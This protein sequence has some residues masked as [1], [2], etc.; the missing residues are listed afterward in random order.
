MKRLTIG[1]LTWAII[2]AAC[3]YFFLQRK[4]DAKT[5]T[6]QVGQYL[7]GSRQFVELKF[8]PDQVFKVGDIL[9]HHDS[10]ISKPIGIITRVDTP[11]S[12]EMGL[13]YSSTAYA[14]L[15]PS[16]PA[17]S[18]NDYV[19][20]HS[21]PDS[22]AWVM[23][24]M[25]P[26]EKRKEISE[27]ILDTY[28]EN[29]VELAGALR[30]I[31]QQTI[32]ESARIIQRDLRVA[33]DSRSEKIQQVSRRLQ[34]DLVK[35]DLIP[36]L[37]EEI[38]PVIKREAEPVVDQVGQEIWKEAS[39]W[40]F[41]WRYLYDST[42]LPKRDLTR[43]EFDR[44]VEETAVPILEGHVEDFLEVQRTI[45]REVSEN[46]RVQ[47]VVS[48]SVREFV[49]DS[50]VQALFAEIVQE[51]LVANP[52]LQSV[53]QEI[54]SS[55]EARTA[56]ALTNQ[57]LEPTITKIGESL[58]GNPTKHITPEFSWALRSRI[59]QKD[60]RWLSLVHDVDAPL[61]ESNP[62]LKVIRGKDDTSNPFHIPARPRNGR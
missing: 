14:K 53:W 39:V 35:E 32:Q 28:K 40:R 20:Y 56:L 60:A 50:E 12:N 8:N 55:D 33:L 9:F 24:V 43:K 61:Q 51:V 16:A 58:F 15:Y 3:G 19:T 48:E 62:T 26:P 11:E 38:W 22:L 59:M 25:L 37:Q 2:L 21:T 57:K 27:L 1:I 47:T 52:N 30:P 34:V 31:I 42:P 5:A 17:L 54:W 7:F 10:G 18:T 45:M 44:F 4:G 36:L 49:N 41:G 29:E 6:D 46:R 23:R 13:V